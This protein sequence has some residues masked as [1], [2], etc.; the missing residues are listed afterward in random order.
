MSKLLHAGIRRYTKSLVF[1][2]SVVST[3][4]IAIWCGYDAREASIDDVYIIAELT[5]L[6]PKNF[7]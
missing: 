7:S 3:I 6:L 2:L 5:V 4:I 1:W